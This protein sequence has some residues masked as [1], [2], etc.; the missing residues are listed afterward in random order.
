MIIDTEKL[1]N[2]NRKFGKVEA[3]CPACRAAG[4]DKTGNHFVLFDTGKFGCVIDDSEEHRL[5]I[6][7]LAGKNQNFTEN[8]LTFSEQKLIVPTVE[9]IY[10]D[11]ILTQLVADYSFY[12]EKGIDKSILARLRAGVALKGLQHGR[13]VFPIY[14]PKGQI[15]G[16][17]GRT[18][19]DS[20]IK[21]KHTGDTSY[22]I[23]PAFFN[24]PDILKAGT[25]ILVES[26]GDMLALFNA[27]IYNV[28]VLFGV[29]LKQS[30]FSYLISLNLKKIYISTNNDD[31]KQ[32]GQKSAIKIHKK[33]SFFFEES[34]LEIATPINNDWGAT[35]KD[36]IQQYWKTKLC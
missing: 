15:H 16:F 12:E 24:L 17:T 13:I 28:L 25:V 36:E 5:Q 22:W 30:L 9:R 18:L 10:P 23:Y 32:V 34:Q 19:F 3:A 29:A 8:E 35:P 6:L 14:N 27:G 4:S 26:I 33:L 2:V 11:T 21:W 20:L 1:E 7:R 31:G